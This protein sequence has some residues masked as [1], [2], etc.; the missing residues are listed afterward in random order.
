MRWWSAISL[1]VALYLLVNGVFAV[2]Y[3]RVGGIANAHPGSLA[4]A[5]YFSVQTLGT[6]GY[7]AMYPAS[8]GA[9]ALVLIESVCGLLF[10]ALATGLVFVRFSL[11]QGRIVFSTKVAIGPF[12]GVPCLMARIGN[13][14]SNQIYDAQMRMVLM[15][16]SRTKEGVRFYRSV[17][18]PLQ[19][20][21]ATALA[22][23]WNILH[24]ID[25]K[26]PLRGHTPETLEAAE[27]E[28][29]V[30]ISGTDDTSL[31]FVHGRHIYEARDVVWG[32]RLADVISETASGDLI[33]DLRRF[34]ELVPTAPT[35]EFPYPVR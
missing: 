12:D 11:T 34:H 29:T 14:R 17:D 18:L 13:D 35:A 20:E 21:R 9:N 10:T 8:P 28:V 4:D 27:A 33:L 24:T 31:Q 5:F 23:S 7:G 6:I 3:L 26:S 19:R 15:I 16:S 2:L 1:I 30:T 32:A 25:E 22:R